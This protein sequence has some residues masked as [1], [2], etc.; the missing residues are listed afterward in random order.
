[1]V[2][3]GRITLGQVG[4]LLTLVDGE[5]VCCGIFFSKITKR[6]KNLDLKGFVEES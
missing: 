1:M 5:K 2:D 4:S 6:I 3:Y